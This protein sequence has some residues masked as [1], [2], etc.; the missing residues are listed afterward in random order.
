VGVCGCV[1]VCVCVCVGVCMCVWF[2]CVCVW[3]CVCVCGVGVC[4]C[5]CSM[6]GQE[7]PRIFW[8][9]KFHYFFHQNTPLGPFLS[10]NYKSCMFL[11]STSCVLRA[12]P[13]LSYSISTPE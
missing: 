13:T 5:V 9:P 7:I 12:L 11:F 10:H 1:G 6:A 4:M 8:P 3:M 2:V